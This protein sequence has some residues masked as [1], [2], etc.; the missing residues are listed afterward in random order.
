MFPIFLVL[1]SHTKTTYSCFGHVVQLGIEDFKG[2]ITQVTIAENKQAI[3]DYG[4]SDPQSLVDG[5][6]DVIVVIQMLIIKVCGLQASYLVA[7]LIVI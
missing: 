4:P 5:D 1:Q 3:W 2:K 6:L 7:L